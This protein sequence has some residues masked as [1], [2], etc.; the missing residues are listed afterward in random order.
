MNVPTAILLWS[1]PLGPLAAGLLMVALT[2]CLAATGIWVRRRFPARQTLWIVLPRAILL[3]LLLVALLDPSC[4]TRSDATRPRQVLAVIDTS[5]SMAALDHNGQ[6]RQRRAE[7]ILEALQAALAPD[8]VIL[9][10]AVLDADGPTWPPP[11][12]RKAPEEA[13]SDLGS[14]L[15]ELARKPMPADSAGILILTDGGDERFEPETLPQTPLY[16]IG[17]G[18][19]PDTYS[20]VAI[21]T[22]DAPVAVAGGEAFDVTVELAAWMAGGAK[23]QGAVDVVLE[24]A[25]GGTRSPQHARIPLTD[26]K[27]QHTFRVATSPDIGPRAFRIMVEPVEGEMTPLNNERRFTVRVEKRTVH[28]LL[29]SHTQTWELTTLRRTLDRDPGILLTSLSRVSDERYLVQ[30]DRRSGDEM[31]EAGFPSRLGLLRRFGCL[32]VGDLEAPEPGPERQRALMDYVDGGGAVIFLGGDEAFGGVH[33]SGMLAPLLPWRPRETVP[34]LEAGLFPIRPAPGALQHHLLDGGL[35]DLALVGD[36]SLQG[37]NQ[38]GELKPG[39]LALLEADAWGRPV[40]V[41]ALQPYGNGV[42]LGIAAN[43]LWRW[44]REG[45][46]QRQAYETFWRDTVRYLAG[47]GDAGRMLSTQWDRHAYR[48]GEAARVTLTVA[49]G[50][51]PESLR[52]EGT[53]TTDRRVRRLNV[54]TAPARP[55]VYNSRVVFGRNADYRVDFKAFSDG[56]LIGSCERLFHVAAQAGEGEQMNVD[57][58]FLREL[59]TQTGGCYAPEDDWREVAEALRRRAVREHMLKQ[60]PWVTAWGLYFG[61]MVIVLVTEWTIRRR[62]NLV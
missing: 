35:G 40:A 39:A 47:E 53:V 4:A 41:M 57:D 55:E 27:G 25:E 11:D 30:G 19:A 49:G 51:A 24:A 23:R 2:A 61:L 48:P 18:A 12:G 56:R 10:R 29:F 43:T 8:G 50:Y 52:V 20:D 59:V 31:L 6:S 62:L 13:W 5:C 36:L 22:L 21:T 26:G 46:R 7:H 54:E 3:V 1:P 9:K 17:I 58:A 42:V 14:C 44:Q 60:R 16:M 37:I 28:V 33:G 38:V 34:R 15:V 32:I 45:G